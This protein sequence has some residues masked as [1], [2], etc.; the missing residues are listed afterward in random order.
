M[1]VR[2]ASGAEALA[3]ATE[4]LQRA[5]LTSPDRSLWEAAAATYLGVGFRPIHTATTWVL[6]L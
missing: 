4:L 1:R 3:L 5:R 2:E 6:S